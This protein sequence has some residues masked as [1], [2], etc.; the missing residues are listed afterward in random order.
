[1]AEALFVE[2]RQKVFV[3][4]EQYNSDTVGQVFQEA[5]HYLLCTMFYN[6]LPIHFDVESNLR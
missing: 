3:W 6:K 2:R 4:I 5:E 1:M